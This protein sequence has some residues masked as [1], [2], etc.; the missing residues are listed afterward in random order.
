[1]VVLAFAATTAI[2][3]MLQGD[4]RV[5][6]QP[7]PITGDAVVT[8]GGPELINPDSKLTYRLPAADW[9]PEPTIGEVGVIALNEGALRTP[10]QCDGAEYARGQVGSGQ[11]TPADPATL[12]SSVA[13]EAAGQ[14]YSITT[15]TGTSAPTVHNG[16]SRP[17]RSRLPNGK[18]VSG[19]V[20]IA[21]AAQTASR[22]LASR[23]EVVVLVLR[24]ADRD[25][26]L[27]VNG[28]LDGGPADPAPATDSELESI[29]NSATPL[30]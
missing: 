17:V 22:C 1:M 24:L 27:V 10:Y 29:V 23:G 5:V 18:L 2:I 14:F 6:G 25:A 8:P 16:A 15:A 4:Q 28:D 9:R 7:S 3:K 13:N 12:A 21:Y 20:S 19:A 26:V 30:S 11:A